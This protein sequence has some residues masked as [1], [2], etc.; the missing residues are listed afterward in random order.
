L[1]QRCLWQIDL[2]TRLRQA[3]AGPRSDYGSARLALVVLALLYAGARRLDY[4]S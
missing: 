2:L 4:L 3:F 1:V